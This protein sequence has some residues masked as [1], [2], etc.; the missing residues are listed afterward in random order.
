M[1]K[2]I[3]KLLSRTRKPGAEKPP[4]AAKPLNPDRLVASSLRMAHELARTGDRLTSV[5]AVTQ[6]KVDAEVDSR[7]HAGKTHLAI[8]HKVVDARVPWGTA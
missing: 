3:K 4:V 1:F 2:T 6:T 7:A 5:V 8:H